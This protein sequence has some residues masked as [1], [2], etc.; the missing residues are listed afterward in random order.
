ML[1]FM[2]NP[3]YPKV[4]RDVLYIVLVLREH[5]GH[6]WLN[7]HLPTHYGANETIGSRSPHR[8]MTTLNVRDRGWDR[9]WD[10]LGDQVRDRMWDR[11]G[12]EWYLE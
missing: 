1:E 2:N 8:P 4:L 7:W 9:L 12:R 10:R 6:D 3:Q 11:L 5:L